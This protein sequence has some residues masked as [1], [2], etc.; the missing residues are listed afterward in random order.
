MTSK[1]DCR[2][3]NRT[4]EPDYLCSECAKSLGWRWPKGHMA[5]YHHG[6]C[7]VCGEEKDLACEDDWLKPRE[8]VLRNWD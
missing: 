1:K 8:S 6:T 3:S 5:T 4:C 2:K 7:D